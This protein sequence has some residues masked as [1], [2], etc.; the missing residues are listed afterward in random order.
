MDSKAN[1]VNLYGRRK[2]LET[3][4]LAG[5]AGAVGL[6][7]GLAAAEPPPETKRI[8]L[9]Q[10]GGICVAPQYVAEDILRAEGFSEVGYVKM[11][12]AQ[13]DAKLAAGEV[14]I[15]ITFIAPL[16]VRVDAGE[17]VVMLAGIHPGCYEL[18]ATN[19]IRSIK[20][21]KGRIVSVPDPNGAHQLFISTI[22]SHV[23]LD[24]KRDIKWVVQP[25]AES[26][27]HLAEGKI[28]A[29]VGF[30]PVPQELRAKKIGQVIF[31]STLDKP[32]SQ[33]FCCVVAGNRE[34][35]KKHPVATKRA[36]RALLKAANVCATEPEATARTLVSRGFTPNYD[37]ALQTMRELPY[38][39]WRD[40]S[41]EDSVRFF[42]LRLQ[43]AGYIK[44]SPKKILAEGTDW[45][46]LNELKKELKT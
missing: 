44:S 45:R 12:V 21:L 32:W 37:Y 14:D 11:G 20:E 40:F 23:G 33:Y 26:I 24:P 28:D 43:E 4:A 29:L 19:G 8:R 7:P 16:V 15:S 9:P 46:F 41:T 27:K 42:A 36:A 35:V 18:F 13:I 31:N 25:P 22:V 3:L 38:A 1:F 2:F 5:A 39:R 17:P 30:P 10:M 34:F 6:R